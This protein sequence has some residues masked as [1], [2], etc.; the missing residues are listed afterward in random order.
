MRCR[1]DVQPLC[2]EVT[3]LLKGRRQGL[4]QQGSTSQH[5]SWEFSQRERELK[6]REILIKSK[7]S[8]LSQLENEDVCVLT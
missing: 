1:E 3:E 5:G 6:R 2:D 4:P 8:T 7:E